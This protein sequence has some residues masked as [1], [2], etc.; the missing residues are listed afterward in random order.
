M[1]V[2]DSFSDAELTNLLKAGDEIAFSRLYKKY[3][4]RMYCNVLKMIKDEA[5]S[6]EIVQE[7][8]T[9]IWEKRETIVI[10]INFAAY[11]YKTGQNFVRDFYRKSQRDQ[12]LLEHYKSIAT[13]HYTHIEEALHHSESE[14]LLKKAL[15]RLSPQ[16]RR[17]YQLCRLDGHTYKEV[18]EILNISSHT[19]KEYLTIANQQVKEFLTNN[20]YAIISLMFLTIYSSH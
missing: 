7:I 20:S 11:I 10:E 14:Q 9:R 19:V 15:S 13:E 3:S 1:I 8:F 4:A 18:A 16:H 12:K 6:E 2:Y 5:S 17:V